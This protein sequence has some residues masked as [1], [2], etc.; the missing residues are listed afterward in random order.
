M[1]EYFYRQAIPL[2]A[3]L[4]GLQNFVSVRRDRITDIQKGFGVIG[5][6]IHHTDVDSE[7]ARFFIPLAYS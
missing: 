7:G 4:H 5:T 2:G 1:V 3:P 6:N